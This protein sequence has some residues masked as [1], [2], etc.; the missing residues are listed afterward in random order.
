MKYSGTKTTILR[1]TNQE[2]IDS[3]TCLFSA[4]LEILRSVSVQIKKAAASPISPSIFNTNT[5]LRAIICSC[6]H[7][8]TVNTV[9]NVFS[10]SFY[11]LTWMYCSSKEI[12]LFLMFLSEKCHVKGSKKQIALISVCVYFSQIDLCCINQKH[13]GQSFCVGKSFLP[14]SSAHLLWSQKVVQIIMDDS[15]N[16]GCYLMLQVWKDKILSQ[17]LSTSTFSKTTKTLF[18]IALPALSLEFTLK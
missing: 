5:S 14:L 8:T 15:K 16:M 3:E 13:K 6:P 4:T 10:N 11:L 2:Q 1:L 17:I 9:I 7:T 18:K 12:F